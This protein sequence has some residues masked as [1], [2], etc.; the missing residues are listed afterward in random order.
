MGRTIPWGEAGNQ[1]GV[2][3]HGCNSPVCRRCGPEAQFFCH[4]GVLRA[5]VSPCIAVRVGER[6][7]G[8]TQDGLQLVLAARQFS[9]CNIVWQAAE[10]RVGVRVCPN[11]HS[12]VAQRPDFAWRHH[13]VV[14]FANTGRV[15]KGLR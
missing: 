10:N 8:L 6:R 7:D 4:C 5:E 2:G 12:G 1:E 15:G 9:F 13:G 14:G 11:F 3:M